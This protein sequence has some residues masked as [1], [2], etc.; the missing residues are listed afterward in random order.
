ML[1]ELRRRSRVDSRSK[2]PAQFHVRLLICEH[3]ML[4]S[5]PLALLKLCHEL[6]KILTRC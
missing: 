5:K 1:K 4:P 3:S 2:D 6:G